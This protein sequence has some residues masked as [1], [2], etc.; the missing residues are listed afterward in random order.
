M[1]AARVKPGGWLLHACPPD[2]KRGGIQ[3][4]VAVG[5]RRTEPLD[6]PAPGVFLRVIEPTLQVMP[7]VKA[8]KEPRQ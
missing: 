7:E 5:V 4:D 3:R 2:R 8:H 1:H 6:H